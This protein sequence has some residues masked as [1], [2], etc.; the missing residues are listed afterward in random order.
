V[1]DRRSVSHRRSSPSNDTIVFPPA[2]ARA[3]SSANGGDGHSHNASSSANGNGSHNASSSANGRSHTEIVFHP[4]AHVPPSPPPVNVLLSPESRFLDGVNRETTSP[5]LPPP[6]FHHHPTTTTTA[7][8]NN[9]DY[10]K[11]SFD[12]ISLRSSSK[13]SSRHCYRHRKCYIVT[14]I[15]A[16][17][18]IVAFVLAMYFCLPLLAQTFMDGAQ[19]HL[20][21]IQ[22]ASPQAGSFTY[23]IYTRFVYKYPLPSI[24]ELSLLSYLSFYQSIYFM[25]PLLNYPSYRTISLSIYFFLPLLNYPSYRTISLLSIYQSIF[26]LPLLNYPSYRTISLLSIYLSASSFHY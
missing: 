15:V 18:L 13:R 10:F 21:E 25:L 22:I 4:P 20:S 26:F 9:A 1:E 6:S 7:I 16:L 14:G 17:L 23:V 19:V 24:I 8:Y 11:P 2:A 12:L 3:S 5:L